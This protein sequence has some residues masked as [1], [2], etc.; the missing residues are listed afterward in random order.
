MIFTKEYK[1]TIS[2]LNLWYELIDG[3]FN[4]TY[5]KYDNISRLFV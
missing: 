2:N 1:P 4:R 3:S 5:V